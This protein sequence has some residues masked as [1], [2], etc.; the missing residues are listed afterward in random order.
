[1]TSCTACEEG[2]ASAKVGA[3][4]PS[5]CRHCSAG[6]YAEAPAMSHCKLCQEGKFGRPT[7]TGASSEAGHCVHCPA[8]KF[9][10]ADGLTNCLECESGQFTAP[11]HSK[12]RCRKCPALDSVRRYDT[13]GL[14]GQ[15]KCQPVPV[16]CVEGQWGSFGTCSKSCGTGQYTRTREPVRQPAS[17][18]CGLTNQKHCTQGWGGGTP[19]DALRWSD[20]QDCNKHACPVDCV[21]T[22]WSQWSTCTQSCAADGHTAGYTD[23]DRA[24]TVFPAYG[25]KACPHV[26]ESLPCNA[27]DCAIKS[28]HNHAPSQCHLEHVKCAVAEITH[29]NSRSKRPYLPRCANSEKAPCWHSAPNKPSCTKEVIDGWCHEADRKE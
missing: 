16:D 10:E 12:E 4:E 13:G 29:H 22:T 24:V 6:Q 26:H 1:M 15:P 18:A 17:G 27:H 8:G 20:T 21:V 9:Q 14:A 11:E 23:R 19:C 2:R 28:R 3:A 7:D 5:S 25:G